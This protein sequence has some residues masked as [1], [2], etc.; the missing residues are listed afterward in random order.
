MPLLLAL[1]SPIWIFSV[2]VVTGSTQ[3][4]SGVVT[5]RR[6]GGEPCCLAKRAPLVLRSCVG[7]TVPSPAP[8]S[9]EEYKAR[10]GVQPGA[11]P[12]AGR[13]LL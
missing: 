8:A 6:K 11:Q 3:D 9:G 7:S 13:G 2:A 1:L 10:M 12:A 5:D 4:V